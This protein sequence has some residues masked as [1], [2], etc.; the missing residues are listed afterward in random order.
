[1]S[2][3]GPS[4]AVVLVLLLAW[5][6]ARRCLAGDSYLDRSKV[7]EAVPYGMTIEPP[8]SPE[9][10]AGAGE[11]EAD[12]P[13]RTRPSSGTPATLVEPEQGPG[14]DGGGTHGPR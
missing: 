12:T 3:N 9:G 14:G 4:A 7:Q 1:M 11:H 8:A 6:P 2:W 10:A 5:G 13:H